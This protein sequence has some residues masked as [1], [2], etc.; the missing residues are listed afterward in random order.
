MHSILF[1]PA[2][3]GA[4]SAEH[5]PAENKPDCNHCRRADDLAKAILNLMNEGVQQ[6]PDLLGTFNRTAALP[7]LS[8]GSDGSPF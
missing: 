4:A 6:P 2:A 5:K 8:L 3:A 7:P 1:Q